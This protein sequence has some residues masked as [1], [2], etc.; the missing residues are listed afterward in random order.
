MRLPFVPRSAL[1][2]ANEFIAYLTEQR[3]REL[4]RHEAQ[5][6]AWTVERETLMGR[7]HELRQSGA[8]AQPEPVALP[9]P[10]LDEVTQA[11]IDTA[12]N[13]LLL[14]RQLSEYATEQRAAGEDDATIARAIREGTE[15]DAGSALDTLMLS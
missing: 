14:R 4:G 3:E 5:R 12:G 2:R 13:R 8:Q 10:R 9:T 7:Y 15:Y 1:D 6:A 11:I